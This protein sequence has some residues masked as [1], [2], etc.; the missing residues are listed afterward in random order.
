MTIV[1]D[2]QGAIIST[3]RP[4]DVSSAFSSSIT[5]I[6]ANSFTLE[7]EEASWLAYNVQ[8]I[9]SDF[10]DR[11]T[12]SIPNAV[13]LELKT[14]Q[15]SHALESWSG[16]GY[17]RAEQD[18]APADLEGW[19]DFIMDM[20]APSYDLNIL[21]A[22]QTRARFRSVLEQLGVGGKTPRAAS[23]LPSAVRYNANAKARA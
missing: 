6:L 4:K 15:H 1:D 5:F 18:I 19:L 13:S 8:Q 11:H 17:V 7:Q 10:S 12:S 20:V 21:A 3:L 23:Y 14:R 16:G 22:A 2:Q 9:M